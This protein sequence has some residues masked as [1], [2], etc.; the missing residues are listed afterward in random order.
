[1]CI[2]LPQSVD[3]AGLAT[4]LLALAFLI[5]QHGNCAFLECL[6]AHLS[7]SLDSMLLKP[8]FLINIQVQKGQL[9]ELVVYGT[10][11]GGN[12]WLLIH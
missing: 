2:L 10:Y 1:M 3:L 6:S 8:E 7:H 4:E 11:E 5:L 9:R 12:K